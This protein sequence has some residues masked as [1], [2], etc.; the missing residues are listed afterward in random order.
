MR[1]VSA[2]TPGAQLRSFDQLASSR[3]LISRSASTLAAQMVEIAKVMARDPQVVVFD[4][5]TS[6]LGRYQVTYCPALPQPA[7]TEN[8]HYISHKLSE[9]QE[10]ADRITVFRNG[11]DVGVRRRSERRLTIWSRLSLAA[12]TPFFPPR[13]AARRTKSH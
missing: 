9:I 11:R 12:G 10:S 5:A 3:G 8:R 4:E 1:H 13:L 2:R 6:A 7:Q